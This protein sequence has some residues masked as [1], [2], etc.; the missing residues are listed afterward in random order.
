MERI[1]AAIEKSKQTRASSTERH[2]VPKRVAPQSLNIIPDELENLAYVETRTVELDHAHLEKNRIVALNKNDMASWAFDSLRTQILQTM[3]EKG[4]RTL[5]IV[6]P[7]PEAGKSV[8]SINLA[9]SIAQQ[10]QRT[11]MLVDL[12]LRRPRIGAYLGITMNKSLN[13]FLEGSADVSDVLVN[14]NVPRLV[15][16]PTA[17]PVAR[18]SEALTSKKIDSLIKDLRNRYES[19]IVIFDLPPILTADDAIAI[20]PKIDCA[21]LVVANGMSSQSDIEETMHLLAGTNLLGVVLN[22]AEVEPRS[23]YYD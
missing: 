18:P 15:I 5:A 19:R 9:M 3:E 17:K 4:W 12:D 11:A 14:P 1:K 23:Y 7:T 13:D 20:L 16:L 22:K 21:M 6:S 8:V 2:V 10:S